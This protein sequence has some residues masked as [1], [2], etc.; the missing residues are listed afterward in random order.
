ML[1]HF[2]VLRLSMMLAESQEVHTVDDAQKTRGLLETQ[3]KELIKRQQR[4][5]DRHQEE[6]ERDIYLLRQEVQ[7]V[8]HALAPC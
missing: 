1:K 7:T 6:T 5:Q 2:S 3:K 4:L 8:N